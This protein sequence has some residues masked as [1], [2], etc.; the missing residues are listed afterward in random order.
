M[1]AN[2]I[3]ISGVVKDKNSNKKLEY[4]SISVPGT[5]I[6]TITNTDGVFS[7]KLNNAL[8]AKTLEIS[9]IGYRNMKYTINQEDIGHEVTIYLIPNVNLLK[10]VIVQPV[11]AQKLVE[12]AIRKIGDNNS[13]EVNML[14]GF[15]RETIKKRRNYINI[16]EAILDIYKTPYTQD[17]AGDRVQVYKGRKLISP[18]PNDTLIVKFQGGPNLSTFMD[19]VKN[20][21]LFLDINTL[22]MYRYNMEESVMIDERPHYVV[23]FRP[24]VV[25]PYALHFGKLYIDKQSLTFSRA[26]FS[27]SMDDRNKA[28]QAILRKKPFKMHFKPEEVSF[29]VTYK[30][31]DGKSYLNYVWSEVKFKCDLKRRLFSTGYTIVSEMVVTDR[32]SGK[33]NKIPF[34]QSFGQNQ[35]LSDKV[36]N[37]YDPNFWEDYNIIEPTES[38]ENAVS[39][40]RKQQN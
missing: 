40:L 24:Q 18:K 14:T 1:S 13:S 31:Q 4:V 10:D 12:E 29:L 30:Q 21:E 15:Y 32:K 20:P 35:V 36:Q 7:I 2:Y 26:E 28:T 6:G 33:I 8:E 16:S 17:I 23:S 27:L 5:N 22:G 34:K 37:F 38:L 3:T 19:V 11:D 25:L 9:H 39:K